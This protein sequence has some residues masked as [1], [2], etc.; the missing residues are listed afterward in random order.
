MIKKSSIIRYA[1]IP[2]YM[3]SE[4]T[5]FNM[6]SKEMGILPAGVFM[7]MTFIAV[8]FSP[9]VEPRYFII[10]AAVFLKSMTDLKISETA[11]YYAVLDGILLVFVSGLFGTQKIW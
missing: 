10:P 1:L 7:A 2:F 9:L 11:L 3:I 5:I 4:F 6:L 8:C